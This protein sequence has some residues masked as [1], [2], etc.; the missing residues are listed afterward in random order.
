MDRDHR[1]V[2]RPDGR[3]VAGADRQH[4]PVRGGPARLQR[5]RQRQRLPPA[6][7]VHAA[8]GDQRQELRRAH[9]PHPGAVEKSLGAER[10]E[11]L[12]VMIDTFYPLKFTT[13]A[14]SIDD[15]AYP[16]SWLE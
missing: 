3:P 7:P 2:G 13:I 16:Y 12:A 1:R 8:E 11:E 14:Q 5:V 9:G 10:T 6:D 4:A 15:A